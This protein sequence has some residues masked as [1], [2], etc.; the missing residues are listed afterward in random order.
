MTFEDLEKNLKDSFNTKKIEIAVFKAIKDNPD[1]IMFYQRKQLFSLSVDA[2]GKDLGF[3]KPE[4]EHYNKKKVA[5]TQFT[6]VNTGLF[7]KSLHLKVHYRHL[8]IKADEERLFQIYNNP[9]FK[10][11]NLLG[12]T[13]DSYRKL[14]KYRIKPIITKWMKERK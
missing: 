7:K 1:I 2:D 6:M 14:L 13:D 12:L 4:S 3:Y 9:S 8:L 11:K 5:G 10:T